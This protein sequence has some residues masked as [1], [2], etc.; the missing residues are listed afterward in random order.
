MEGSD[1]QLL[2]FFKSG[3]IWSYVYPRFFPRNSFNHQ[4]TVFQSDKL[5]RVIF[6]VSDWFPEN[7]PPN[8]CQA[9]PGFTGVTRCGNQH[10]A[11]SSFHLSTHAGSLYGF[12]RATES[13]GGWSPAGDRRGWEKTNE[14]PKT[15]G[16]LVFLGWP[17]ADPA[18]CFRGSGKMEPIGRDQK[19]SPP[20]KAESMHLSHLS[21]ELE[22]S[23]RCWAGC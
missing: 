17:K 11:G 13:A 9:L 5:F 21:F 16:V 3:A 10:D 23:N 12:G 4:V 22:I 8:T 18:F 7:Q 20:K 6:G 2:F 19:S 14:T 1:F 15:P